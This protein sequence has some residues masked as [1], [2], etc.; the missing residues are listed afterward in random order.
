MFLLKFQILNK[1]ISKPDY[2]YIF[3]IIHGLH[4]DIYVPTIQNRDAT[5]VYF[6]IRFTLHVI[7][8][9]NTIVNLMTPSFKIHNNNNNNMYS[10]ACA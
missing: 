9:N 8:C 6:L 10:N 3:L 5:N 4:N 2:S 1:K 7:S